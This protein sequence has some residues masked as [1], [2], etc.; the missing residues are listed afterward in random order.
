MLL[1][2]RLRASAVDYRAVTT[3]VRFTAVEIVVLDTLHYHIASLIHTVALL[4]LLP[5]KLD[6]TTD[7]NSFTATYYHYLLLA[8]LFT[9][10]QLGL[11]N[12]PHPVNQVAML[13][14][15]T[16]LSGSLIGGMR[17]TQ[18][19]VDLCAEKKIYPKVEVV[20]C[21]RIDSVFQELNSKSATVQRF[22]LDIANTL[23]DF[24]AAKT[25]Q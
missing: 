3:A 21:S 7:T 6:H 2:R 22:V 23:D 8:T 4:L 13:W 1:Q 10:V 15:R 12:E 14:T 9:V 11:V 20:P 24:V 16:G 17:A 5:C 19:V 18:E 25:Q